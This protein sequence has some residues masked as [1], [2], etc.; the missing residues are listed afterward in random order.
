M[1][2]NA[3]SMVVREAPLGTSRLESKEEPSAIRSLPPE[4]A[5][6]TNNSK[7]KN[8]HANATARRASSPRRG[9]IPW[10]RSFVRI[11]EEIVRASY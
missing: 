5:R 2:V 1:H 10:S 9:A 11:L 8:K 3:A 4:D 6:S 7:R